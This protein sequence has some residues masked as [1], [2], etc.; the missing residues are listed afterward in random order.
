MTVL[1]ENGFTAV[2][3]TCHL[4]T[5][6]DT[7]ELRDIRI[8]C[9]IGVDT[10]EAETTQTITV[11]LRYPVAVTA[12]ALNDSIAATVDYRTVADGLFAAFEGRR[13]RLLET[14]AESVAQW[15]LQNTRVAWVEISATKDISRTAAKTATIT[16]RRGRT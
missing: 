6:S 14:L 11:N 7:C 13:I 16:I 9:R 8:P 1:S 12:A 4:R 3:R 2:I 10:W 5:M 15:V